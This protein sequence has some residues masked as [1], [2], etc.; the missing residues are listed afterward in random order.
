MMTMVL[1]VVLQIA[2]EPGQQV[3]EEYLDP[4]VLVHQIDVYGFTGRLTMVQIPGDSFEPYNINCAQCMEV[5]QAAAAKETENWLIEK[6]AKDRYF[7]I[8]V[9]DMPDT[10]E[11]PA[12]GFTTNVVVK[13]DGGH[14]VQLLMHLMRPSEAAKTGRK[15]DGVV[16]LHLP[17]GASMAGKLGEEIAK[18]A[19]E[20]GK[21]VAREGLRFLHE[22]IAGKVRCQ[23]VGWR[24]PYR[25][26]KTVVRLSRLCSSD[27]SVKSFWVDYEITNRSNARL[28]LRN[29]SL[30]SA[31]ATT[32]F[33]DELETTFGADS[34][35][36]GQST[37]GLT[38]RSLQADSDV[39][40][41]WRLQVLPASSDRDTVTVDGI[42][43]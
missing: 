12:E 40:T 14:V 19:A 11:N 21:N 3:R 38:H 41:T 26:D 5:Q 23:E 7:I 22:R 25:T 16:T 36:F 2:L 30:D 8:R 43:F 31:A 32:P 18:L 29:A 20:H 1:A 10:M 4:S 34:L 33:S 6:H 15:A 39:P 24:K 17:A 9:G 37:W 42:V 35:D 27:G 13:L 28:F